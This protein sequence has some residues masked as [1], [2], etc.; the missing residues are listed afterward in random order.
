MWLGLL[1]IHI[2]YVPTYIRNLQKLQNHPKLPK[3]LKFIIMDLLELR[4]N[5]WTPRPG[6]Q[7]PVDDSEVIQVNLSQ[8]N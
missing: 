6:R 2:F 4:R 3:R 7:G 1:S 8:N 5:N